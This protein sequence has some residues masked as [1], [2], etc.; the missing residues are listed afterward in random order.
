MRLSFF[1][2]DGY[3]VYARQSSQGRFHPITDNPNRFTFEG[4]VISYTQEWLYFAPGISL[5]YFLHERFFTELSFL[6][7]PL[8]LCAALDEHKRVIIRSEDG[9]IRYGRAIQFSD[10]M[11]GGLM[12]EPGLRLSFAINNRMGISW[13]LSWRYIRGTRGDSYNRPIGSGTY[14]KGANDA[15]A[16]FSIIN[17][18][19][20]FRVT[21]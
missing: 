11:R 18:A 19:L 2:M 5:G 3:G 14:V 17:T 4:K 20:C 10:H 16:G 7:S 21:L 13:E 15:G 12:I 6:I 9:D 8:I 1:G